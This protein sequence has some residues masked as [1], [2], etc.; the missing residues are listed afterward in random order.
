MILKKKEVYIFY[1]NDFNRKFTNFPNKKV[2]N[3]TYFSIELE[4]N[5]FYKIDDHPNANGHNKIANQ[6]IE[7]INR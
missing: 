5:D 7:L 4:K 2:D 1:V 3:I 6:I